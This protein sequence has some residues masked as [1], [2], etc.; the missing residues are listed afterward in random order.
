[1]NFF[2]YIQLKSSLKYAFKNITRVQIL[3]IFC[4]SVFLI[5][6]CDIL[7]D[8]FDIGKMACEVQLASLDYRKA[9]DTLCTK[10]FSLITKGIGLLRR[11][12]NYFTEAYEET[13]AVVKCVRRIS[14]PLLVLWEVFQ[15]DLMS[16]FNLAIDEILALITK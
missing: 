7:Y 14:L 8:F 6:L 2:L 13:I 11:L 12:T 9:F 10:A 16:P 1:M 5:S 3:G 15:C 4:N